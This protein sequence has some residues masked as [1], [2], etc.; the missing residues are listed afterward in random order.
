MDVAE[1][2][3]GYVRRR[4]GHQAQPRLSFWKWYHVPYGVAL[5]EYHHNAVEPEGDASVRGRAVG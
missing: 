2:L 5:H 4:A 1:L 3:I